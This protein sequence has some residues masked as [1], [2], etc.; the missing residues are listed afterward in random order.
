MSFH[1]LRPKRIGPYLAVATGTILGSYG[2]AIYLD[3][4]NKYQFSS[5]NRFSG[6]NSRKSFQYSSTDNPIDN[7]RK[8]WK[9]CRESQKTIYSLI[10]ANSLVFLAWKIPAFSPYLNRY[11]LH[12]INSA[13][14]SMLGSTFS[15]KSLM[16]LGFNMLA[17]NSFGP[18]L[19]DRMGREQFLA[20]YISAGMSSSIVSHLYKSLRWNFI[21][22]LG[23]SGAIFGLVGACAHYPELKV[24]L[25]FLPIHSIPISQALPAM[26]GFDALGMIMDWKIFDHAAHLGGSLFGYSFYRI[27]QEKIWKN[28]RKI[29]NYFNLL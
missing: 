8:F 22:S 4:K 12:S 13:P 17:L 3:S 2:I 15:H 27:S 21:P 7:F 18:F 11:F 20:F 14:I 23:A 6:S 29:Q 5:F 26:M 16:H 24:S 19:H 28:R 25:I 1:L 10:A 9:Q